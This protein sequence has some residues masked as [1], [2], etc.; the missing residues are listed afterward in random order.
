MFTFLTICIHF[1]AYLFIK[2]IGMYFNNAKLNVLKGSINSTLKI[3]YTI[4]EIFYLKKYG[5]FILAF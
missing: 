1:L 2:M 3:I 5:Y 4:N